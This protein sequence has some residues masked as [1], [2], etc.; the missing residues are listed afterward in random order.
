MPLRLDQTELFQALRS[1]CEAGKARPLDGTVLTAKVIEAARE[2]G[3]VLNRACVNFEDYT[4]HDEQHALRVVDLMHRLM[5]PESTAALDVIE[6]TLLILAAFGHDTGMAVGR[7]DRE[8]LRAS[9]DY[10]DYLLLNEGEWI[11]A[12]QALEAKNLERYESLS[13][14]I[15]EDFLRRRHHLLSAELMEQRFAHL[16]EIEGKS[17]ARPLA[18]LCKSHGQTVAEVARLGPQPFAGRFKADLP[19][20]ACVLRLADYLDLDASRAPGSLFDLIKPGTERSRREWRKHQAS[21]FFVS[22]R[23]IEFVAS[24]G[25]FFEE[26]ALRDTLDGIESERRDCMELL[27][28]RPAGHRLALE[29]PV[30]VRIESIGYLYETF[31]FQLEYREIMSLLMGTH[32]YKDERVFVRELLQ[33][34][35]DACRHAEAA[36][37][38]TGRVDYNG[39]IRVARSADRDGRP[40]LEV[41]DNGSGM[42]RS[43]IR[44]Y[45]MRVGRSYYHSFAFRRKQLGFHP[46]SK[47]G[48]GILSCFM[49][50]DY[51]EVETRPDPAVYP[52]EGVRGD[53]A[54]KLEIRGPLEFFVVRQTVRATPGTTVRVTLNSPLV[55]SLPYLVKRFIG[56]IPYRLEVQDQGADPVTL[57]NLPFDF[58]GERFQ[59][60]FV[61]TPGSFGYAFRDLTFEGQFGFDLAGQ[62]RFFMLEA[63]GRRHL[64]LHNAGKYSFVGFG[65]QGETLANAKQMTSE[66]RRN[67]DAP[68]HQVRALQAAFARECQ[69]DLGAILR[70][71]DR[72]CDKLIHQHDPEEVEAHW[73]AFRAQ[74]DALDSMKSFQENPACIAVRANLDRAA[75][76][77]ESFISGRLRLSYPAGLLTQDGINLTS[78]FNLPAKL[79]L[80]IGHLYNLDLCG[81]HRLSLNAAR[82]DVLLDKRYESFLGHLCS[83]IGHFLGNWFREEGISDEEISHYLNSVPRPLAESVDRTFRSPGPTA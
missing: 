44:D 35:L 43:V 49:K 9:N 57:P 31:Q 72:V 54:L 51:I 7:E 4:L 42:T 47:F 37:R 64:R 29:D 48:I 3:D 82:D 41:S 70:N 75:Q 23:S 79:R 26:K 28:K 22:E 18:S 63:S 2:M 62:I 13:S 34:A 68:L 8:R 83:E 25:D 27:R 66:I 80:G 71:F 65:P 16:L 77:V 55:E 45:F 32:L 20:L 53:E 38:A 1:K 33:N 59:T 81:Q 36:Q 6:V 74:V 30:D 39:L 21:N 60:A 56:R 73:K 78:I 5:G 17:L 24:F 58:G 76:E 19:F 61:S 40:V 69:P 11:E 67:I 50:S 10:K 46:V 12:Q 52:E 14:R 15:F